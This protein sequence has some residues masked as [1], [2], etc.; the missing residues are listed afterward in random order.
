MS[1]SCKANITRGCCKRTAQRSRTLKSNCSL[2]TASALLIFLFRRQIQSGTALV[3]KLQPKTAWHRLRAA[4]WQKV[5]CWLENGQVTKILLPSHW[6]PKN[7][8]QQSFSNWN[9]FL[10]EAVV[11]L[12]AQTTSQRQSNTAALSLLWLRL[13][14]TTGLVLNTVSCI[15]F[16]L[17]LRKNEDILR[18]RHKIC[19]PNLIQ[20]KA[21]LVDF[22]D[23]C[24]PLSAQVLDLLPSHP[25]YSVSSHLWIR[26][27]QDGPHP[28]CF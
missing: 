10:G 6:Q 11:L 9:Q 22:N 26:T 27:K 15:S 20:P 17:I 16:L 2:C 19:I 28:S 3:A 25:F 12:E 18:L 5:S 13:D 8:H 4:G 21:I 23:I 24:S 7:T 1:H 14:K